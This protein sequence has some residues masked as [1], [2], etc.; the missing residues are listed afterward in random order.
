M[1]NP[2]Y[3]PGEQRAAAVNDLF[4]TVARR[5]DIINDA[6][7]LGWHRV[8]KRR[9]LRMSMAGTGQ[10]AL[11]VCCGTGDIAFGLAQRG[12]RVF[13]IDFN[14]PMLMRAR[15]RSAGVSSAPELIRAD[16][17]RLPFG[18]GTFDIVTVGYGLRNLA[19]WECGLEEMHRVARAG[20]RLL[21]LDFGK[22][23]NALW[24]RAYFAYLKVVVPAIGWA[25]CRN[26]AAYAYILESL[27]H[28]PAQHGVAAKMRS[29]GMDD[30]RIVNLWGGIMSINFGRKR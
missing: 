23:D 15:E 6:M 30:V 19:N 21:A 24:R 28:H 25:V 13:G 16:A 1:T 5:Y 20:G 14:L 27:N 7:S 18:D 29:M 2:F 3:A 11:D 8:W 12:P 26:A 4:T 17:Q 10:A 9:L 22:P